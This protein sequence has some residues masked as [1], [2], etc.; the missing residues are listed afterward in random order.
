[1]NYFILNYIINS[2]LITV[3]DNFIDLLPTL[4]HGKN[5]YNETINMPHKDLHPLEFYNHLKDN[6]METGICCFFG[7]THEIFALITHVTDKPMDK[8][9]FVTSKHIFYNQGIVKNDSELIEN[10]KTRS[11]KPRLRLIQKMIDHV[12]PDN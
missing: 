7:H 2:K 3:M 5:I 4:K 1:M 9:H 6:N 10:I 8:Y 11:L 12:K